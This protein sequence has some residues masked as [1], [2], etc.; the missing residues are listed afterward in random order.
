[1]RY[2]EREQ[3]YSRDEYYWGKESNEL[4][5]QTLEVLSSENTLNE[6][7]VIDIGAGEGRDAVFFAERGLEVYATDIS[8]SGLTKAN[9]LANERGIHIHTFEADVNSLEL[10]HPVD[11]VYSIG[12]VQYI[13][14]ANRQQQFEHF[15][16][17]TNQGGLHAIFAFVDHPDIRTPPDWTENEF[18]Y[19]PDELKQ[20]YR[21]WKLLVTEDIIFEDDSGD[22]P[23]KHAAEMLIAEKP[24]Q[25]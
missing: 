22:I 25:H 24:S 19:E 9:R 10:P 3:L 1:M 15:R 7:T 2:E 5:K 20:Y 8:S 13:E 11:V 16:R 14:P 6:L 18:F 21:N 23:H 12:A 17:N 4:A